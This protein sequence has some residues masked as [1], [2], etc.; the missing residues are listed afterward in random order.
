MATPE[1][2]PDESGP[3][4]VP[5]GPG[6]LDHLAA[7]ARAAA[8]AAGAW[9]GGALAIA[10]GEDLSSPEALGRYRDLP[11]HL[12]LEGRFCGAALGVAAARHARAG[13]VALLRVDLLFVEPEARRVGVGDALMDVML[14]WA[15]AAGLRGIDVV[16]LPGDQATKSFLEARGFTARALV[17][18][19]RAVPS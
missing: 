14:D 2:S 8:E 10:E 18:H 17:L 6:G 13:T 15:D 11:G 9:R 5:A 7:L 12:L 3:S 1:G 16:A 19:R 4:A